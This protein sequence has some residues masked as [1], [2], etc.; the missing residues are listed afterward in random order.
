M[1]RKA[2]GEKLRELRGEKSREQVAIA[3]G[4]TANAIWNYESG[5]RIPNDETKVSLARYYNRS[6]ED[7][8]FSV[9]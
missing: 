1:D 3:V 5:Q 6:V 7:I 4:V 8:F 9:K 2:I